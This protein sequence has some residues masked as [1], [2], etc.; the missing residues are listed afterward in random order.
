MNPVERTRTIYPRLPDIPDE[1][2]LA[3]ITT[4]ESQERTFATKAKEPRLQYLRILYLKAMAY[5]GHSGFVPGDLPRRMRLQMVAELN[6]PREFAD[7]RKIHSVEKSRIVSDVRKFLKN[8]SL[9]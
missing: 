6:L 5:L 8:R 9:H 1:E 3:I 7:I 2:T 4:V